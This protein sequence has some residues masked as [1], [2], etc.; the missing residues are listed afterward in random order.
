M[1]EDGGAHR[2]IWG[3]LRDQ[4]SMRGVIGRCGEDLLNMRIEADY[5]NTFPTV[6]E[7]AHDTMRLALR[8]NALLCREML[9][10]PSTR[11]RR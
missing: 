9:T 7:D 2:K 1:R 10:K 8:I 6:A 3:L 5:E 4:G 11:Y